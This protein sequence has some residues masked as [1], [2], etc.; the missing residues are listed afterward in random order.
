MLDK[1]IAVLPRGCRWE[2]GNSTH[3]AHPFTAKVY[4]WKNCTVGVTAGAETPEQALMKAALKA[5]EQAQRDTIEIP[6]SDADGCWNCSG[7]TRGH[8]HGRELVAGTCRP[9]A[10]QTMW[11][12][13]VS[14]LSWTK[15]VHA[16]G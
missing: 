7:W 14:C 1:A 3:E 2:L 5:R 11:M 13:G 10:K 9:L 15:H 16:S 12:D 8:S 4:G 6:R